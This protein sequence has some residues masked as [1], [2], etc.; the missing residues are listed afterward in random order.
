MHFALFYSYFADKRDYSTEAPK[1]LRWSSVSFT[2]H[3][4]LSVMKNMKDMKDGLVTKD[5]T[6]VKQI[7]LDIS[8][9]LNCGAKC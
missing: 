2:P 7:C 6:S 4:A 8:H 5:S 3:L 9:F 1:G